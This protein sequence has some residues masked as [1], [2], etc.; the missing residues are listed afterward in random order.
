MMSIEGGPDRVTGP[1]PCCGGSCRP[2]QI[3][4]TLRC[5]HAA[6]AVVRNVPADV[7]ESCGEAQ[8]TLPTTVQLLAALQAQ[9]AP[10]EV[11]LIPIYDLCAA[12][13]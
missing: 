11:A 13:G 4:L 2:H 12:A 9:R 1:C 6:F 8:F 5:D 10:D 3:T 7:C